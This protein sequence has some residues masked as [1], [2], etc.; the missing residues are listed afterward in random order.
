MRLLLGKNAD[1]NIKDGWART[2]LHY[3]AQNGHQE[4]AKLLL[5]KNADPNSKVD[6]S[7]HDPHCDGRTPLH[8]AAEN[9]HREVVRLLLSRGA[10]F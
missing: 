6:R 9:G 8:Y 5:N 1:P 4:I 3:V 2:L 10:K 7:D